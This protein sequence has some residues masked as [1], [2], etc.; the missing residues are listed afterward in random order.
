MHQ[1]K[2]TTTFHACHD[3]HQRSAGPTTDSLIAYH[4]QPAV[5]DS[6]EEPIVLMG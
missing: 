3:V 6:T 5:G 2:Q 4:S 1:D